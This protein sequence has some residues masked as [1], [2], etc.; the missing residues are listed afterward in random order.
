VGSHELFKRS[1][2]DIQCSVPISYPQACLGTA[3]V[4]PTVKGD[5]ELEIPAG[6]PSGRVF[7]LRGKGA[8]R[9]GGRGDGDHYVQVV[10][11]VPRRLS[12]EEEDLLRQLSEIQDQ[13]VAE[14]SLWREI[15]DRLS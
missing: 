10:V 15:I 8:P 3:L 11:H 14:K 9:L 6:T 5:T 12:A 4:V 2:A 1:G 7:T 13:K